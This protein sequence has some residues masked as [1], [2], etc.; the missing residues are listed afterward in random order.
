[1]VLYIHDL[2]RYILTME[3]IW[4]YIYIYIL[5]AGIKTLQTGGDMEINYCVICGTVV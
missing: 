3:S 4:I 5:D 1:M 2:I